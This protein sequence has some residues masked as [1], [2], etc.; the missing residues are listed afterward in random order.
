MKELDVDRVAWMGLLM[1]RQIV[2]VLQ[3]TKFPIGLK[4]TSTVSLFW[5]VMVGVSAKL[6]VG[7]AEL[8]FTEGEDGL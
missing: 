1:L 3:S 4:Y 8:L 5:M 2:R 6:I 7:L